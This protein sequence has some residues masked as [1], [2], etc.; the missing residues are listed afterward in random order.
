MISSGWNH[1]PDHYHFRRRMPAG[2]QLHVNDNPRQ[3]VAGVLPAS[4]WIA[5][6]AWALALFWIAIA[7]WAVWP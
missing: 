3:R 2:W 7:A 4:P 6:I 1:D 5:A